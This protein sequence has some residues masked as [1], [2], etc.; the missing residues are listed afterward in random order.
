VP[1]S[2]PQEILMDILRHGD[3]V[4]VVGNKALV[5]AVARR[6]DLASAQYRHGS[7]LL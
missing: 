1:Y 7:L 3:S 4:T 5:N 2:A 6:L